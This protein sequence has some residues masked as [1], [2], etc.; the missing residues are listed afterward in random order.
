[1]A[2]N[3]NNIGHLAAYAH[4][5]IHLCLLAPRDLAMAYVITCLGQGHAVYKKDCSLPQP[6]PLS[7]PLS[8]ILS[9]S[10]CS[11]LA[12]LLFLFSVLPTSLPSS[13]CLYPSPAPH[14]PL[15]SNKFLYQVMYGAISQG[16]ILSWASRVST[17]VHISIHVSIHKIFNLHFTNC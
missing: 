8:L 1:M 3:I 15:P 5:H 7:I 14:S 6:H 12:S 13:V 2:S 4:T 11:Q 9:V 10:M 16:D 17:L